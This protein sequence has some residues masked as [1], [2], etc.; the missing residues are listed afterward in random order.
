MSATI[1][2]AELELNEKQI[3]KALAQH[4]PDVQGGSI[5][6]NQPADAKAE[7][8]TALK[9]QEATESKAEENKEVAKESEADGRAEQEK[10]ASD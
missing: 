10:E 7:E 8:I 4:F 5:E 6:N 3:P 1:P 9:N 2:K